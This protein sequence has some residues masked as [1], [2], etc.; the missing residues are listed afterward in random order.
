MQQ[1][2]GREDWLN[3]FKDYLSQEKGVVWRITGQPGIG[4][5]TLL[6]RFEHTCEHAERPNVWLDLENFTPAQGLEVLAAMASAAR[7]FDTEKANKGWKEKAGEGFKT[8]SGG[9]IGALELGKDLIPGGGL[10]VGAAKV[11]VGLGEGVAGSAAQISENAAANH[12]ELYLLEALAKA[13]EKLPVC[14][15]DTYEHILRN[16]LKIQSRL[17]LG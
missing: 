3:R 15:I 5:S 7:F 14:L 17:V 8:V 11:L 1:F 12:P 6:R 2:I 13:G 10:A 16:D 4:K 9:L